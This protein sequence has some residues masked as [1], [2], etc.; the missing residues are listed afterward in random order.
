LY[1]VDELSKI[2]ARRLLDDEGALSLV[3]RDPVDRPESGTIREFVRR[4]LCARIF[5]KGSVQLYFL[6][7]LL[8]NLPEL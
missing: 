7:D 1:G 8:L 4:Q 6:E 3:G 5:E 2:K